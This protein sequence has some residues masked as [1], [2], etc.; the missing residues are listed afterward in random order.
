MRPLDGIKDALV[1]RGYQEVVSYS[2]VD[3][4]L[5]QQL[6]PGAAAVALDNPIAETMAVMRTTLWSGLLPTWQYNRQRQQRR[7]RLFE[8]GASYAP[9]GTGSRETQRL[10]G[11]VAGSALPEQWGSQPE[12]PADFYDAKADLLALLGGGAARLR[13]ERGEHPA[14][15]PGQC[16]RLLLDGRAVGWLGALH[17]RLSQAL[18][19]GDSPL[20]FELELEAVCAAA[21]PHPGPVSEFPSSRRD[22][23]FVV[24]EEVT[25]EQLL[26][27]TRAAGGPL[28]KSVH[29]F[30]IYHG[31]NLPVGFKSMALGLIF[32]DYSRTLNVEEVDAAVGEITA[33]VSAQL[34]AS[35][36]G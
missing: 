6:D 22:R 35:V 9:D 12:R 17:P 33:S 13:F 34:G 7:A 28:L 8:C 32:Q 5:Q 3:P 2:F 29:I 20:L 4:K 19:L 10:A 15:H 25:A 11:L 26:S 18:D 24:K 36:R 27:T 30:D 23:A 14:L 16:A 21:L 31:P 1:A